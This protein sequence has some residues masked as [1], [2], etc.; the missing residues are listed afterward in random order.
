MQLTVVVEN[1]TCSQQ[2]LAEWGY[3]A[4]LESDERVILLDTGGIQHTLCHNLSA[5]GLNASRITDLIL[6]HGHFDHTSGV[7]DILRLSLK[8]RLWAA[9]S[10][11]RERLGDKDAKRSSGG[12]S[13]LAG[14]C[15]HPVDPHIEVAP[16][17]TAFTVPLS[18]RDP[19]W[20]CTHHMFERT[21]EGQII[22]DT[23]SDDVS[24]LIQTS[25]GAS[26]LLGCAHAGLPNILAYVRKTFGIEI[27]DTVLGGTHLSS[28][29]PNDYPLWMEE[30]SKYKILHWR[31]CHC[32]GFKAA[33]T[34]AKHFSDV[35]WAA[36]G[37]R[38]E[39]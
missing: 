14:L 33:A 34:L 11:G 38:H 17:I 30:L 22:P 35:D 28:V 8:T 2:L 5:L 31:P 27:F 10:I 26:V 6:S 36:A 29:P 13:M 21:P 18:E 37:T 24:V 7:M 3:C 15:I 4:W 12:G 20:V 23:F 25:K 39:L 9:P 19:R 1:Q 32:T 16:G